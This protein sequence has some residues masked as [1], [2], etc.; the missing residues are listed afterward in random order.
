MKKI[1]L[2][3]LLYTNIAS[4]N[5]QFI[6]VLN[7]SI[8]DLSELQQYKFN[9]IF[10]SDTIGK[11]FI[12][13]L[14]NINES[15]INN[16]LTFELPERECVISAKTKKINYKDE[17][18]YTWVGEI[19]DNDDCS[20]SDGSIIII[21]KN[22]KFIGQFTVGE[23]IYKLEDLGGGKQLI[24]KFNSTSE[25]NEVNCL[26][27]KDAVVKNKFN[28]VKR[29]NDNCPVSVLVL[30]TQSANNAT[31]DMSGTIALGIE[32]MN[33][34]LFRSQV[35]FEVQLAG[36]Q[37]IDFTENTPGPDLEEIVDDPT[38]QGLRN[39]FNADLV[40]VLTETDNYAKVWGRVSTIGPNENRAYA[41]VRVTKMLSTFVF[42][43]ELAHLFGCR[44]ENTNDNMGPIEHAHIL[45]LGC[46]G[47]RRTIMWSKGN[48]KLIQNFSNPEVKYKNVLTGT[49]QNQNNALQLSNT[50]CLVS[51]FRFNSNI[52]LNGYLSGPITVC[53]GENIQVTAN[54]SGGM[55]GTYQYNWS[56]SYDGI[57]YV[58]LNIN[59]YAVYIPAQLNPSGNH[60][61][62]IRVT[63]SDQSQS[64]DEVT[65][66][67]TVEANLNNNCPIP[68]I[69]KNDGIVK[70]SPNPFNDFLQ[71]DS[72]IQIEKLIIRDY[73]GAI[74]LKYD[75]YIPNTLDFTNLPSGI[76]FTEISADKYIQFTKLIKY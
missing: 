48:K 63:V 22:D 24:V 55:T 5:A 37:E 62:F 8:E 53:L 71:I 75:H 69:K 61:V 76:Y 58:N 44:H 12:V 39:S 43:H 7:N 31:N 25:D 18:N 32:Q 16:I 35:N 33:T 30:F 72:N 42:P 52:A 9:K 54:I 46:S 1:F 74:V 68:K 34:A 13:Q 19:Q 36:T 40:V 29:S 17:M 41:V 66:Y 56:Y 59:N 50:N 23:D 28:N 11:P 4:I 26:M 51:S 27:S 65:L 57:N 70:F 2:I 6:K 67:R 10:P 14:E 64:G 60:S 47:D 49:W 20:C 15:I 73:K 45:D 21:K 38:I 3:I